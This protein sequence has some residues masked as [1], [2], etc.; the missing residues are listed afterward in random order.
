MPGIAMDG[1]EDLPNDTKIHNTFC[2]TCYSPGIQMA[3]NF[4]LTT[5]CINGHSWPHAVGLLAVPHHQPVAESNPYGVCPFCG[6]PGVARARNLT[7][8]TH[9]RGGHTWDA[10]PI[11][12]ESGVALEQK[13]LYSLSPEAHETL[14]SLLTEL[15]VVRRQLNHIEESVKRWLP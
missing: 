1:S 3:K 10:Y 5:R 8:T 14:K 9:C 13:S 11:K 2:P 6:L 4:E 15:R 7:G 12:T